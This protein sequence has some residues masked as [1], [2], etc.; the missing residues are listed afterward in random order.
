ML[1]QMGPAG[2]RN[3]LAS[4]I[5]AAVLP[6]M[7]VTAWSVH[8]I[9]MEEFLL[10]ETV[11]E[12]H[13]KL[14][15]GNFTD[16]HICFDFP[17]YSVDTAGHRVH[18]FAGKPPEKYR[19]AYGSGFFAGGLVSSGGASGLG[20]IDDAPFRAEE[21]VD[22]GNGTFTVDVTVNDDMD[23]ILEGK[24]FD[25]PYKL[26]PGKSWTLSYD[27]VREHQNEGDGCCNGSICKIEYI[28]STTITNHGMW[29]KSDLRYTD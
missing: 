17:T 25:G 29:R 19:I 12:L 14:V 13:T 9:D 23:V 11:G 27:I 16:G 8:P 10:V 1:A 24:P 6:F 21:S 5:V 15:E 3:K 22:D 20:F 7:M 4:L 2:G 28:G 18:Q 26:A